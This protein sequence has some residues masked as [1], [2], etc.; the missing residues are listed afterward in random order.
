MLLLCES[1]EKRPKELTC[2]NNLKSTWKLLVTQL[3]LWWTQLIIPKITRTQACWMHSKITQ[4][5]HGRRN[6]TL[7]TTGKF[8][9]DI[10]VKIYLNLNINTFSSVVQNYKIS[11]NFLQS[12]HGMQFLFNKFFPRF[13]DIHAFWVKF[14]NVNV[15]SVK[16]LMT[17]PWAVRKLRR[18]FQF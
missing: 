18:I 9:T 10:Y 15:M 11:D 1:P 7:I 8:Y 2:K 12:T 13:S 16:E 4:C 3:S 17:R 6:K 5:A 14:R